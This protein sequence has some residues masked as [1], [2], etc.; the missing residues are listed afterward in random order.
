MQGEA[1]RPASLPALASTIPKEGDAGVDFTG[2]VLTQ[3]FGKRSSEQVEP[4]VRSTLEED[5]GRKA[6]EA[7][8]LLRE[9]FRE[10]RGHRERLALLCQAFATL[11]GYRWAAIGLLEADRHLKLAVTWGDVGTGTAASVPLA[12]LP[13][14]ELHEGRDW[15][16]LHGAVGG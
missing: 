14:Q 5:E 4:L 7:L 1:D 15:S 6:G 12:A 2:E 8:Q 13:G 3:D 9:L 11:L 10:S 16:R